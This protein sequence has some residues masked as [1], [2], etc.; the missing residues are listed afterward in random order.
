MLCR[1]FIVNIFIILDFIFMLTIITILDFIFMF[2]TITLFSS[3]F[4][5]TAIHIL[6]PLSIVDV[7]SNLLRP[8]NPKTQFLVRR[9][10]I[11][12]YFTKSRLR[13]RELI[14]YIYINEHEHE[15]N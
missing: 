14:N 4:M 10:Y 11:G 6:D 1:I 7:I 9:V 8:I 2:N 12:F 5:L 15:Q 3:I 13:G